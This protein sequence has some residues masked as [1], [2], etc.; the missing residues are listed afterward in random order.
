M[1]SRMIKPLLLLPLC[2]TAFSLEHWL[3]ETEGAALENTISRPRVQSISRLAPEINC[4]LNCT[5]AIRP[6][7]ETS[8]TTPRCVAI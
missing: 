2:E 8:K 1:L 6:E 3:K 7:Y 5:S 4:L